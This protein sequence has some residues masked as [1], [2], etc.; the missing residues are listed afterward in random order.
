MTGY[1]RRVVDDE[2]DELLTGLSAV[3][4]DGPK[5]VGKSATAEVR[6]TTTYR[7]DSWQ[8][9]EVSIA[10]PDRLLVGPEPI[11]ID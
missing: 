5:G 10:A 1:A 6:A 11:L 2:L 4:L 3:S 7:L 8:E 9:L